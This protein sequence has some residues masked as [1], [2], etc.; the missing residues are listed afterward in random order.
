MTKEDLENLIASY[1]GFREIA[2]NTK[3][4]LTTIR[5]WAKK[6]G[7]HSLVDRGQVACCSECG[8]TDSNNFYGDRKTQCKKCVIRHDCERSIEKKL[9]AIEYM[10]GA[11]IVCGYNRY[12][13]ALHFHHKNSRQKED[14]SSIR[15]WGWKRISKELEKCILVCATCHSEIHG[16]LIDDTLYDVGS[17]KRNRTSV[18]GV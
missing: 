1:L 10:G 9:K 5:Y 18:S 3:W 13:G 2:R 12:Y 11:C 16:G 8:E 14:W 17:G 6:H 4:S 15:N 7:L